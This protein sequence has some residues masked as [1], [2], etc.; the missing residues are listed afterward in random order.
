MSQP[1]VLPVIYEGK[2]SCGRRYIGEIVRNSDTRWSSQESTTGESESVK[3]L[4]D[5][6]SHMFKLKVLASASLHFRKIKIREAFFI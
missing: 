3:H 4:A 1:F 5:I 2:C 6:K